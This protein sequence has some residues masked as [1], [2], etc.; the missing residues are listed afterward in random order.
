MG[1]NE[2]SL[3]VI[4]IEVMI[5]KRIGI[6]LPLALVVFVVY[7]IMPRCTLRVSGF[8]IG[9]VDA[10]LRESLGWSHLRCSKT[11][12]ACYSHPRRNHNLVRLFRFVGGAYR[13]YEQ[14]PYGVPGLQQEV[15]TCHTTQ[16]YCS[17]DVVCFAL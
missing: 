2:G 3:Q 14:V 5:L 6:Y 4:D 13:M 7:T 17:D 8:F 15:S 10:S 1:V 11:S 16:S 9:T 12:Q